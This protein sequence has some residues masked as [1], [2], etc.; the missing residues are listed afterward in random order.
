[1]LKKAL[2]ILAIGLTIGLLTRP[3]D[4]GIGSSPAPVG[5]TYVYTVTTVTAAPATL[6]LNGLGAAWRFSVAGGS[7]T[8]S[9]AGGSTVTL[10]S[11]DTV[12]SNFNYAVANPTM[13]L[14]SL[15]NGAT[16][17]MWLDGVN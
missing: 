12:Q 15:A 2:M 7:A 13:T 14:N 9:I 8:F 3:T 6:T 16:V 4:A 17:V 1:M 5:K 11:A 10:L